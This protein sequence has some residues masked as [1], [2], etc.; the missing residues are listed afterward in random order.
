[1]DRKK[2]DP[3]QGLELNRSFFFEAVEPILSYKFQDLRYA[4]ALIGVGSEVLGYDD[5]TSLDH[6]WGPRVLLFLPAEVHKKHHQAIWDVLAEELPYTFHG[7]PTH[8]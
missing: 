8:F 2:A 4:A 3:G 7:Y 1:M 5:L 6:H